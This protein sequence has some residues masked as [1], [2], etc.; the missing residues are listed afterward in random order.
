[1]RRMER[2]E[3]E[4]DSDD[5]KETIRSGD[6][7]K[8]GVRSINE[9]LKSALDNAAVAGEGDEE[10]EVL[11][12]PDPSE[13]GRVIANDNSGASE[14]VSSRLL[15]GSSEE[16]SN[17]LME[18]EERRVAALTF[19]PE[20]LL[21]F[22]NMAERAKY[23]PVRLTFDERKT[24]RMVNA[25]INVSDYTNSVDVVFKNK[26]KRHHMQLQYIVAFMSGIV[27]ATGYEKGQEVLADRN[28]EPH[29]KMLK[30]ALEIARR[31]KITN[32]E[33]M[34]SE[35]GK[36]VFLMQDAVS[37]ETHSLLGVDINKPIQTVHALLESKGGLRL[38]EDPGLGTATQE[39]LAEKKDKYTIQNE[40]KRKEKA[41]SDV[42]KRH[43]SRTLKE[44]DIRIC[45]YSISD[46]NSFLNSNRKPITDCI[47]LL[48]E[49]FRPSSTG[50]ER[51]PSSS[52]AIDLGSGGSRLS[53][54][55]EMQYNYVLQSLNLWAA[56]V[57]DT[58][59]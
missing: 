46:N 5:E 51:D 13:S 38:L 59:R 31:Y 52:L 16:E 53:H 25:A 18:E 41:A 29:E 40:I 11:P 7:K 20:A 32:P 6:V 58:F 28:F 17:R 34:R 47:N 9:L 33:K 19:D 37:S 21:P 12:A 54:S 1:M 2:R 43:A 50:L 49:Y 27:A 23:I 26:A 56:I 4:S 3:I 45:L 36:L 44:D 24:L 30:N 35:Y 22:E 57:E 14:K 10:P 8:S 55:H 15:A 48:Q 39:I 42:V